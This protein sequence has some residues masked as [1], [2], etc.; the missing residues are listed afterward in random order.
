MYIT[1]HILNETFVPERFLL[2]FVNDSKIIKII[3]IIFFFR[4]CL[5]YKYSEGLY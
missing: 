1:Y 3:K 4:K 2:L 5:V